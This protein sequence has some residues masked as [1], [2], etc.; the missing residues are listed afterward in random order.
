MGAGSRAGDGGFRAGGAARAP[1]VNANAPGGGRDFRGIPGR[2]PGGD[3]PRPRPGPGAGG[4][5]GGGG[6][7]PGGGGGG[8]GGGGNG[9]GGGDHGGGHGGHNHG[10]GW[11]GYPYYG[12][13]YG[14]Y[15]PFW[16]YPYYYPY[17]GYGYQYSYYP[18][19]VAEEP[20]LP[21]EDYL[22]AP[23]QGGNLQEQVWYYCEDPAGYYP[24]VRSCNS[25]WQT[26]PAAPPGAT[27]EGDAP[28]DTAEA[29]PPN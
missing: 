4:G 16:P 7:G 2:R 25:Q 22:D 11:Y 19:P 13:G 14:F 6:G 20:P 8:P 23:D 3:Y 29:P 5:G 28:D 17:G 24:Y 26:V 21:P 1:G 15:D 18:P 12:W 27:P 9:G 10:G